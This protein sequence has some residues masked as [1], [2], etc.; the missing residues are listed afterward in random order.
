M[1]GRGQ[2][3]YPRVQHGF[4]LPVE[5]I[6]QIRPIHWCHFEGEET[7]DGDNGGEGRANGVELIAVRQRRSASADKSVPA[8]S[9]SCCGTWD[10]AQRE[11]ILPDTWA[12]DF[13]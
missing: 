2:R 3:R 10:S 8:R 4:V 5:C 6:E 12:A 13:E 11:H 1:W 7:G 9:V